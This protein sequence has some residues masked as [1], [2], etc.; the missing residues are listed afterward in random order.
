MLESLQRVVVWMIA[1]RTNIYKARNL[2]LCIGIIYLGP[3]E[4][5]FKR[6]NSWLDD[7]G[8]FVLL[9]D[10]ELELCQ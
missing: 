8:L 6:S 10:E 2:M 9:V 4:G 1:I 5:T 3:N 7:L